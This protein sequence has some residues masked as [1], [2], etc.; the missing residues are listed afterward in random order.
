MIV[1]VCLSL[2]EC[3]L[4]DTSICTLPDGSPSKGGPAPGLGHVR[5]WKNHHSMYYESPRILDH[6][7]NA[8]APSSLSC[9][10]VLFTA[11]A[12]GVPHT[13]PF[14]HMPPSHVNLLTLDSIKLVCASAG[15]AERACSPE[16]IV[17]GRRE[18]VGT[19]GG[20]R[21]R[22]ARMGELAE[23]SSAA[24]FRAFRKMR[25]GFTHVTVTPLPSI[26]GRA[27]SGTSVSL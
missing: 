20:P 21:E 19:D 23:K 26:G 18:A 8:F 2:E 17:S 27:F 25:R 24:S 9:D 4:R 12:L 16:N 7:V 1:E 6:R 15:V 3:Y 14:F 13:I 22:V 11:R 10:L 5:T